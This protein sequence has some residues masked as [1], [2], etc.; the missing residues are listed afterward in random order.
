M[1]PTLE[2]C[3]P[4][5]TL[6]P[7]VCGLPQIFSQFNGAAADLSRWPNSGSTVNP[8]DSEAFAQRL[9]ATMHSPTPP[10]GAR[11][12]ADVAD[13]Y[14]PSA[15]AQRALA[16]CR[17]RAQRRATRASG[18]PMNTPCDGLATLFQ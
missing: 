8:L 4:L 9:L 7:L 14:A 6:E 13:F 2:D 17:S 18:S 12:C 3:W 10:P 5:A 16:S 11:T 15:Q 1:L